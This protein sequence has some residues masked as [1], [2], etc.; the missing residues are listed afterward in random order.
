MYLHKSW[1]IYWIIIQCSVTLHRRWQTRDKSAE[2]VLKQ[3]LPTPTTFNTILG[4]R[5]ARPSEK[6]IADQWLLDLRN[7]RIQDS[8]ITRRKCLSISVP[9]NRKDIFITEWIC[10]EPKICQSPEFDNTWRSTKFTRVA[11]R[12]S[13]ILHWFNDAPIRN[14]DNA[15]I[16]K[17]LIF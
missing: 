11:K 13:S 14:T 2:L 12:F 8:R 15:K 16:F 9:Q 3:H 7:S 4:S 17:S 1:Q 6:S 5:F 10:F